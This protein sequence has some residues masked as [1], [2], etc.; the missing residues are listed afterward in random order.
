MH[1]ADVNCTAAKQIALYLNVIS[2]THSN[3]SVFTIIHRISDN[4]ISILKRMR[5]SYC[6]TK[7][8][9]YY[10]MDSIEC[11]ITLLIW[12][13]SSGLFVFKPFLLLLLQP[14]SSLLLLLLLFGMNFLDAFRIRYFIR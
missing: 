8:R 3:V 10:K 13:F 11:W 12:A 9:V 5:F 4:R 14:S 6:Y 2:S 7:K 1:Y